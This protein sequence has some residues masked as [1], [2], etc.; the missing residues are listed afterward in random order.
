VVAGFAGL[1]GSLVVVF[2][3]RAHSAITHFGPGFLIGRVW[4]PATGM[5][6]ALPFIVGTL[7]TTLIAMVVAVPVG[8]GCALFLICFVSGRL[9]TFISSAIELLA[10]IPS[11][12]YGLWAL[13]VAA[14]W[15]RTVIEPAVHAVLGPFG[16]ANGPELGVGLLLAGLVL[17]VMVLPTM[18]SVTRDV[19]A[20]VPDSQ[21]ESALALGASRWQ[22]IT[23]VALPA[24]RAGVLGA[25]TLAMGRAL[26]ETIAVAMVIGDTP[27]VPHSLF[28][29][30][31]TMTSVLANE[32]T[33]ATERFHSAALFEIA[34]LLLGVSVFVNLIARLLARSIRRRNVWTDLA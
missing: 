3:Y 8:L 17:S 18:V 24:A 6:G 29:P 23:R 10:G 15:V 33:E 9:R 13:Q 22:A 21:I 34:L 32:F 30:A 5:F 20:A 25:T 28:A 14:P 31:D 2:A 7:E 26:G 12:V 11:V 4:S 1:A 27:R 19:I 16:I